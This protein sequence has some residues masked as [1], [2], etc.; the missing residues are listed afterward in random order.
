[1]IHKVA[2]DFYKQEVFIGTGLKFRKMYKVLL[3]IFLFIAC[4]LTLPSNVHAATLFQDSF[5]NTNGTT[6][7]A[8]DYNYTVIG[9]IG[10]VA[11]IQQNRLTGGKPYRYDNTSFYSNTDQCLSLDFITDL[12]KQNQN[13]YLC[14]V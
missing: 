8:H 7:T 12:S 11:I 3:S 2:V 5:T 9:S 6:L 4:L 10:S 13:W 1:M 14:S